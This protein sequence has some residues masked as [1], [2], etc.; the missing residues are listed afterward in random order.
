MAKTIKFIKMHGLGNDFIVLD[1]LNQSE[2]HDPASLAIRFCDRHFGIGADGLL[3]ILPS[4]T[5]DIRMQIFNADGSEAQMCGNGIRCVAKYIYDNNINRSLNPSVETMSGIKRLKLSIDKNSTVKYV[6]VDMGKATL[7]YPDIESHLNTD[8]GPV[9]IIPVSTGNPHGVMFVDKL[10]DIDV[11][12]AGPILEN[13]PIWPER[14]NIEFVEVVTPHSLKQLTWERGAGE[15]LACGTGACAAATAAVSTGRCKW[16][17]DVRLAGGIIRVDYDKDS[18]NTLITGPAEIVFSGYM[19]V[20]N[21][22]I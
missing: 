5:A 21:S 12:I 10:D 22:I 2:I 15:T 20:D 9:A 19:P 1:C 11:A 6:T 14:A 7:N 16:P 13:H 18:D 17:V 3:I 4:D 8:I